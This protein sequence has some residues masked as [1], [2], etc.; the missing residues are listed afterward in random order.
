MVPLI[1]PHV[2]FSLVVFTVKKDPTSRTK[3]YRP[4][5]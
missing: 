5:P 4:T 1:T 2:P 3:C